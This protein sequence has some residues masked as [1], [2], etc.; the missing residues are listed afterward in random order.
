M[1]RNILFGRIFD[2]V[3]ILTILYLVAIKNTYAYLDPGSGSYL[4]QMIA[5]GLLSSIFV[6]KKFWRNIKEFVS[7]LLRATSGKKN[8]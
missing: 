8:R 3:F 6:I 1:S 5:A 7:S 2:I 4:L